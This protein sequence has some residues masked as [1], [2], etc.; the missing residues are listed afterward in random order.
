LTDSEAPWS[1]PPSDLALPGDEVHVWRASLD[2]SPERV[3]ELSGRLSRE[4]TARADRFRFEWHKRRFIVAHGVLR[5]V[6]G[7][8]LHAE[9]ATVRFHHSPQGKPYLAR[10]LGSPVLRFNLS[11]SHEL[12]LL[13]CTHG[14]EIGV[15]L[16]YV[17]PLENMGQIAARFFSA[18]ENSVFNVLSQ[19]G[20]LEAFYNCW[21]RKEAYLKAI[22]TGLAKP[23]DQFDVSLAPGEAPRLLRVQG[24][25]QEVERWSM[26]APVAGPDYVAAVA[27][28]GQ[29]WRLRYWQWPEAAPSECV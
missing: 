27:V 18:Y 21:T 20:R 15:D 10:T 8:Y 23:L 2:P 1:L 7:H 25:P 24:D 12:M 9:P 4:E 22:G 13:A 17:R 11:H 14:H 6:L 19:D 29:G 3:Q 16:E 5:S 28:E 26:H